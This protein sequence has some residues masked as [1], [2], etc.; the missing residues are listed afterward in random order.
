[1]TC[2]EK[3]RAT[4]EYLGFPRLTVWQIA[5]LLRKREKLA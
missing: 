3:A 4:L 2:D 1:M 5:E